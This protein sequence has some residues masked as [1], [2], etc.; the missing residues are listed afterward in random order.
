MAHLGTGKLFAAALAGGV[1]GA[2]AA[3]AGGWALTSLRPSPPDL[4]TLLHQR[5]PLDA[6]EEGRLDQKEHVFEARRAAIED[7]LKTANGRL[8]AAIHADPR[9]S[10]EVEAATKEVEAAAADL[11]RTTL[12]HIFEMRDGLDPNHRQAYDEVLIAALK[13]GA[14]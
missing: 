3:M 13:R 6:A 4:H 11:Q 12:V 14:R 10:P 1:M 5:V 7:R 9:W 2:V 8:A